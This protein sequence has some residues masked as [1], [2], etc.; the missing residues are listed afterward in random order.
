MEWIAEQRSVE[1]IRAL[2]G[3][4]REER[5]RT[6]ITAFADDLA[7]LR[8]RAEAGA[9]TVDMLRAVRDDTA[10][11]AALDARLDSAR[12]SVDRSAHGDDLAALIAI[13][14]Y[15]PDPAAFPGW[16]EEHLASAR[17]DE[18]GV[19]LS[20]VHRAKGREWPHVVVH[21]ATAGLY[22]HRLAD[23]REEERRIF[24]VAVTR[25][26]ETLLVLAGAPPSPFIR[27]LSEEWDGTVDPASLRSPA[28]PASARAS[29]APANGDD[30]G[31]RRR[32]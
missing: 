8:E 25:C 15:A 10:L 20:T 14:G 17:A 21:E 19:H 30:H 11:G 1:D 6:R 24:H 23:D 28:A 18:R 16:L 27:E 12:R 26:R 5:D 9:S 32:D 13:A 31:R 2:A 29:G 7:L 3:R 22:P 4:M